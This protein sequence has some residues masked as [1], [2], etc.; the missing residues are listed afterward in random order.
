M[1]PSADAID[2][3]NDSP[4]VSTAD[5]KRCTHDT[6]EYTIECSLCKEQINDGCRAIN[7][8]Y[9]NYRTHMIYI[10]KKF[11]SVNSIHFRNAAEW[12]KEFLSYS[13]FTYVCE[14][15]HATSTAPSATINKYG[16]SPSLPRQVHNLNVIM[17]NINSKLEGFNTNIQS[18]LVANKQTS[19]NQI[20]DTFKDAFNTNTSKPLSYADVTKVNLANEVKS[21]VRD[22][23]RTIS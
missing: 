21:A 14:S 17:N 15:C 8:Q 20:N 5:N 13:H 3:A 19:V 22:S 4:A 16:D 12:M 1:N 6:D 23:I 18:L 9:C 2:A 7:C 10:I 11:K